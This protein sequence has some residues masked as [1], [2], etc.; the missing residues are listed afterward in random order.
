MLSSNRKCC[1]D[2]DTIRYNQLLFRFGLSR[3]HKCK[4]I[5][6]KIKISKT[7]LLLYDLYMYIQKSFRTKSTDLFEY[8]FILF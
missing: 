3:N 4:K 1:S 5:I 6:N 7:E 8:V 2:P